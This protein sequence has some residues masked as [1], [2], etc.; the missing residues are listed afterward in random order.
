LAATSEEMSSQVEQLQQTMSFFKLD[1]VGDRGSAS[2]SHKQTAT[3]RKV[4][5][6]PSSFK[7]STASAGGDGP[8]IDESKFTK[9]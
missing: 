4:M 1:N 6:K 7:L 9:F 3:K 5:A 8:H 2:T